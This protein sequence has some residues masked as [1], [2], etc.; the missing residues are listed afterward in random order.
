MAGKREQRGGGL[1]FLN[2][3]AA[4]VRRFVLAEVL[5]PA[6]GKVVRLARRMPPTPAPAQPEPKPAEKK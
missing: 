3:R 6:R 2:H 5:A 4:F 1:T